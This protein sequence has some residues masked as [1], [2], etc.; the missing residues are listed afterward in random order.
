MKIEPQHLA[1]FRAALRALQPQLNDATY[2]RYHS[3]N[4]PP[5]V[6][7]LL[8]QPE[9][10]DALAADA[11]AFSTIKQEV[12]TDHTADRQSIHSGQ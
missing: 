6:H 4:V 1:N 7:T 2:W 8:T 10:A 3:R 9:L 12:P 11:H 5:F